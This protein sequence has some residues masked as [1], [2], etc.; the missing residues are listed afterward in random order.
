MDTKQGKPDISVIGRWRAKDK[1]V[2][3]LKLRAT[4]VKDI[5]WLSDSDPYIR[6]CRLAPGY[7]LP[8]VSAQIPYK[9]W[10]LI[11]YSEWYK[12]DLNPHFS[13]FNLYSGLLCDNNPDW[14]LKV[15]IWDY[16]EKKNEPHTYIGCAF[17]TIREIEKGLTTLKCY[18][19]EMKDAGT[20]EVEGFTS[21]KQLDILDYIEWGLEINSMVAIDYSKSN[22]LKTDP[23][24]LHYLSAAPNLYEQAIRTVI[25]SFFY[26]DADRLIPMYGFAASFPT[27]REEAPKH[28]FKVIGRSS[29]QRV[30]ASA[31]AMV[32]FYKSAFTYIKESEPT[33]IAPMLKNTIEWTRN[34]AKVRPTLYTILIIFTDGN[35]DDMPETTKL[36]IEAAEL[37][38]SLVFVGIGPS[39]F[40]DLIRLDDDDGRLVD[41]KGNKPKRDVVQFVEFEKY[42]ACPVELSNRIMAEIPKQV[43]SFYDGKAIIPLN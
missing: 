28:F 22:G 20:I 4:N 8:V 14:P 23:T 11:Y 5:E 17:F 41:D 6:I 21:K 33:L 15:E 32:H 42:K 43:L 24:S 35:I 25:P 34:M 7:K 10:Y 3:S 30:P 13:T 39:K 40:A 26:Y 37:P 18:D 38:I 16:A 9:Y 2:Y 31:E 36:I 29:T 1:W 12:D 27:L 19:P